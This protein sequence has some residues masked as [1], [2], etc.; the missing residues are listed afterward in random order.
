MDILF[1]MLQ[2]S[3]CYVLLHFLPKTIE[4]FDK[5]QKIVHAKAKSQKHKISQNLSSKNSLFDIFYAALV[6]YTRKLTKLN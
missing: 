2:K 6:A 1:I 3:E 4:K 5:I